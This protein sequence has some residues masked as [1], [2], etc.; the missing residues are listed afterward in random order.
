[1]LAFL[2]GQFHLHN[3]DVRRVTNSLCPKESPHIWA[4]DK[5]AGSQQLVQ[6]KKDREKCVWGG[7]GILKE[8]IRIYFQNQK[9][10]N[11][12]KKPCRA[13][14]LK[15]SLSGKQESEEEVFTSYPDKK[16]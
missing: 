10:K 7:Y 13:E 4:Q 9:K 1:M 15:S 3:T 14:H 16:D 6:T 12:F 8:N 2:N 11:A 5:E